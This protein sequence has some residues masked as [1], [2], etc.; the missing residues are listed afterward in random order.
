ML[1]LKVRE[2]R[3]AKGGSPLK[4]FKTSDP[5][6]IDVRSVRGTLPSPLFWCC[7]RR[8]KEVARGVGRG[9]I[10]CKS[11]NAEIC[12]FPDAVVK[13]HVVR[14]EISMNNV[15]HFGEPADDGLENAND[16]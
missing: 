7:I 16:L 14:L 6:G 10:L 13:Q 3:S 12:K 9:C 1:V 4:Q 11:S 8:R 15:F 2:R 5:E